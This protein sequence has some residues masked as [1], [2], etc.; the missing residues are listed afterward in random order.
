MEGKQDWKGSKIGRDA[1]I[2]VCYLRNLRNFAVK[3]GRKVAREGNGEIAF[4]Y[5]LS[6]VLEWGSRKR[7]GAKALESHFFIF[8]LDSAS[9]YLWELRQVTSL[10]CAS[11]SSATA[12]YNSTSS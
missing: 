9:Y 12:D 2:V 7:L 11:V 8:N 3:G 5:I 1:S 6:F 10:I 4:P